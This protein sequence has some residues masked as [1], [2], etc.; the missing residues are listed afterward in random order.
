MRRG[1]SQHKLNTL[2]YAIADRLESVQWAFKITRGSPGPSVDAA[3]VDPAP[4]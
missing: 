2:H 1:Y 4:A 3:S